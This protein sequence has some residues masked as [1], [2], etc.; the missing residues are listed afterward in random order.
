MSSYIGIDLGGTSIK[1][2]RIENLKIIQKDQKLVNQQESAESIFEDICSL[3]RTFFSDDIEGIGFAVPALVDFNTGVMYGL[4][5]INQLN[6]FPI[7]NML[8]ER[9]KVPVRLQNDAN[10]FVLGEKFSGSAKG[11]RAVVGLVTGTGVGAGIITS[12]QLYTGANCGAGE[13]GMIPYMDKNFEKYCSGQFFTENYN[14]PGETLAI[15]AEKG[16]AAA[17][18]AFHLY[19]KHMGE[20]LKLICYVLDPELIILGGSVSKSFSLYSQP[21]FESL[22]SYFFESGKP[23]EILPSITED[24]AIYGA[25]SLFF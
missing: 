10:C 16:D 2:G 11:Y 7:Q 1:G 19:G 8:S 23:A 14:L 3:I 9:F 5:N 12:G 21:M 20:L 4:S 25:A 24:V 15:L 13:F 22:K 18:N 17:I 6:G